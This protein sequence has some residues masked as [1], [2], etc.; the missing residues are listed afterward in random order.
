MAKIQINEF[1]GIM[2]KIANDKLPE[3]MAQVA[4]DLKTASG[5]LKA[6]KRSTA[7]VA[8]AST[9]YKTF[10]EYL[11]GG[12]N[13]WV[14]YDLIVHW[15]RSPIANDS[16]ERMYTT[17]SHAQYKAFVNDLQGVGD[18][19]FTTDFYYPGAPSA[20][21]LGASYT[22]GGTDYRA[23]FYTYVSRYGEEGPPSAIVETVNGTTGKPDWDGTSSIVLSGFTEPD[24][25]D[26]HLKTVV[27]SNAP[28][29]RIYRTSTDGAGNAAFLLV[30]EVAVDNTGP[31]STAWA[32]YNYTDTDDAGDDELLGAPCDCALYDR[33]PDNL[34]GLRGHPNGY[35]VAHKDNVLYFSEPF[36]PWAWP[37]DYQIPV[38]HEIIS[39][40]I[41]GSTIV[42]ATDGYTYTFT[43]PHPTSL[44]KNKLAFQPCQSQ[45]GLVETDT[46]VMFPSYEGFQL[47]DASGITNVTKDMFKPEDW[48]DFELETI[49]GTWFNKAYYGFYSSPTYEG[50][51]IIDFLNGAITTGVQYHQAGFVALSDGIFRT[52]SYSDLTN[53]GILYIGQWDAN[54]TQFRNFSYKSPRFILEK[55]KNFKV[56]QVILDTDFYNTV[57]E[58]I[59]DESTLGDLN[60]A[61]WV[62]PLEGALNAASLNRQDINGDTLYSLS[63]LGVQSYVDFKIYVDGVLKFTKQVTDSNMFKLPRGF[64]DKKWELVLEGMIPVKRVTIATSTEE[65]V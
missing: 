53:P 10:F 22:T 7:D 43:G 3:N 37:Q 25:D 56:A 61:A 14:Y 52:I 32:S 59:G 51:V 49:H 19:D 23:Y 1:K 54:P 12:N 6:F 13:H 60:A 31:A 46:G 17:G 38:D 24:S 65:I 11:E 33:A 26:E 27:G 39:V 9:S 35:F 15:V 29:I 41:F 36:K 63:S 21:A 48:V 30:A 4:N 5:E 28:A 50:H 20:V 8:L 44:Y 45:R 62:L 2:P 55:P 18:F 58:I 42:V 40:G 64:K 47:V 34:T 16:F 57:L